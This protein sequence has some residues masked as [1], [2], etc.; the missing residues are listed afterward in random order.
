MPDNKNLL[1]NPSFIYDTQ[2]W[3][4][5]ALSGSTP[6]VAT[7]SSDPL[8]GTGYSASVTFTTSNPNSG[9]VTDN[10]YSVSVNAGEIGRAHV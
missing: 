10:A 2:T 8:Y 1:K 9:I 3:V 6:T 7:D 5:L 4:G